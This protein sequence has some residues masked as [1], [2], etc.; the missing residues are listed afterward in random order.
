METNKKG[1]PKSRLPSGL[2]G[3]VRSG[4]IKNSHKNFFSVQ[5]KR[6]GDYIF[7]TDDAKT[8]NSPKTG[9]QVYVSFHGQGR[10]IYFPY[11]VCN[12]DNTRIFYEKK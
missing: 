3:I 4:K 7:K 2:T 10:D 12:L 11:Q 9:E 6:L 1:I 8:F 5:T